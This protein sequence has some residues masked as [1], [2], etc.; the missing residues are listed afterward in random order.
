MLVKREGASRLPHPVAKKRRLGRKMDALF[1]MV[2]SPGEISRLIA[3]I[4]LV[5]ISVGYWQS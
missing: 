1:I 4:P 3:S 5:N 2:I